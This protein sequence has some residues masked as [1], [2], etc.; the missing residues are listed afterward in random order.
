MLKGVSLCLSAVMKLPLQNTYVAYHHP[1]GEEGNKW[2]ATGVA[3]EL[4]RHLQ[5]ERFH[6]QD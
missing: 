1:D 4:R 3:A 6:C 5:M 2:S